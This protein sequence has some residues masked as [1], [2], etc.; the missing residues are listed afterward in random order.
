MKL[1]ILVSLT[2]FGLIGGWIGGAIDHGNM[3]GAWGILL[4]GVGSLFGI[5]VGYKVAQN[6]GV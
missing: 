4:S 3:F 6:F 1:L 2:V 5:W